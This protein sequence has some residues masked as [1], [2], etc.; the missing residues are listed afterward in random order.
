MMIYKYWHNN[1]HILSREK[2]RIKYF[3]KCFYYLLF[4]ISGDVK[5]LL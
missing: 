1:I 3:Q 4:T 5:V 2:Y